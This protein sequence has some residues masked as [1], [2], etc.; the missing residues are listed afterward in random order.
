MAPTEERFD[1]HGTSRRAAQRRFD[2]GSLDGAGA[3]DHDR[4]TL[5]MAARASRAYPF[6]TR[7]FIRCSVMQRAASEIRALTRICQHQLGGIRRLVC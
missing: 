5:R 1:S 7:Q 6:N 4:R 2:N 3:G